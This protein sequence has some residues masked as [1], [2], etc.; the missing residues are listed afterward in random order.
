[1]A[2][3]HCFE[4]TIT[5]RAGIALVEHCVTDLTTME[6]WLNPRLHCRSL[7]ERWSTEVGA[8]SRFSL[9][10]LGWQPSLISTV[11][12]RSPHAI[13]WKFDGFFIGQDRWQWWTRGESTKLIN[14]FEFTIPNPLVEFGFNHLAA[15]WTRADMTAQL[16]RLKKLAEAQT[17]PS[18]YE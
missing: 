6:Q 10:L 1:M 9:R 12:E 7:E 16:Q 11:V 13:V 15:G 2:P 4:Q 14:R 8:R 3:Y 5:I 17:Q 18:S